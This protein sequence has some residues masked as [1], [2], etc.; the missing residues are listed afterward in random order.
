M[1]EAR[2]V[3]VRAGARTI[4]DRASLTVRAGEVLA[5]IGPNGAGKTTFLEAILG[6]VPSTARSMKWSGRT[7]DSFADR[8]RTFAYVP[9]EA[10]L[11][12][13]VSVATAI[14]DA[15]FD[16][17]LRARPAG[18]LSRGEA[19]RAWLA[20][21]FH[22]ERPVLVLDEPFGVFDPLQLDDV[23]ASIRQATK[24]GCAVVVSIH[25][26]AIAEKIAD[27]VTLLAAG[28]VVADG[29]LADVRGD[30]PSLEDAFRARLHA[31]S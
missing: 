20:L 18:T 31:A 8:A 7:L 17:A 10:V 19:K 28:K 4:V 29:T 6:L 14:F 23:L 16:D 30:H 26:I 24:R 25:Q 9:D 13:E 1:L 2:E 11:P 27:R 21:A 22:A 12:E 3:S 15:P 5:L